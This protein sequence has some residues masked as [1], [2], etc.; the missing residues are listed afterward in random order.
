[1]SKKQKRRIELIKAL[2]DLSR[3]GWANAKPYDYQPLEAELAKLE[4][5]NG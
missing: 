1:M 3:N 4:Q 2:S 5:S